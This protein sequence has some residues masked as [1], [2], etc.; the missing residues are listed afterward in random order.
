[1]ELEAG[2]ALFFHCNLLHK[3]DQ[4]NSDRRRW[5][6]LIAYNKASN[7]PVM[8][9]HCPQYTPLIKVCKLFTETVSDLSIRL[10]TLKY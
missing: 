6:F 8:P 9:H 7:D 10:I 5:A 1:M 4:N 3:S 2:D